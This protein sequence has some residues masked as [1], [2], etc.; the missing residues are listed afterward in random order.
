MW[1][2]EVWSVSQDARCWRVDV[3]LSQ[4]LSASFKRLRTICTER[5]CRSE[6]RCLRIKK[7]VVFRRSY[8]T[9][10]THAIKTWNRSLPINV[11]IEWFMITARCSGEKVTIDDSN[12]WV[13]TSMA[14][15]GRHD[16][17]LDEVDK[18]GRQAIDSGVGVS[19]RIEFSEFSFNVSVGG[20]QTGGTISKNGSALTWIIGLALAFARSW[21]IWHRKV[22]LDQTQQDSASIVKA[23]FVIISNPMRNVGLPS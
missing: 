10:V 13:P 1:S 19:S 5:L 21:L 17:G 18:R 7:T 9:N 2:E 11:R 4:D 6:Y 20:K 3:R 14:E 16:V 8:L 22:C 12:T 15:D 23:A